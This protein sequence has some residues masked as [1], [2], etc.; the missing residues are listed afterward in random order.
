[1]FQNQ[2]A[3]C[4]SVSAGADV[5]GRFG[6]VFIS[7]IITINTRV[8]FYVATFFTLIARIGKYKISM[9]K[10]YLKCLINIYLMIKQRQAIWLVAYM[11]I[12]I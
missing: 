7:S 6:L 9:L 3:T 10:Y 11:H 4:I 8:L 12:L 5:A 1:M 2:V